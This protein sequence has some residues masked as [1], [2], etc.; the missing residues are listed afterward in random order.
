IS[1]V[2]QL[3]T[4]NVLNKWTCDTLSLE[5]TLY[6]LV[7]LS[8]IIFRGDSAGGN[9]VTVL[10]QTILQFYWG[11][12][13]SDLLIM[14]FHG[15]PAKVPLPAGITLGS[16]SL[17][18]TRRSA[19]YHPLISLVAAPSWRGLPPIFISCGKELLIDECKVFMWKAVRQ[20]VT[21]I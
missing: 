18:L 15:K 9:L 16:P 13:D 10:L 5:G 7:P 8:H 3:A 21:V 20:G 6:S 1:P 17:D 4:P 11:M 14:I 12:P 19:L 2:K